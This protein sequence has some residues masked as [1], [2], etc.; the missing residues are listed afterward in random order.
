[1]DRAHRI[2]QT[3]AVC[4]YRLL[5]VKN[6]EMHIFQSASLN[7]G[8]Y[9]AVLAHQRQ[10]IK[11]DGSIDGTYK[12]KYKS[13]SKREIQAKDIDELLKKGSYD[14]FQDYNDTEAQQFMETDIYHM[15]EPIS[16]T[17]TYGSSGQ[18]TM[19]SGI[20]IFSKAICFA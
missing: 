4:V 14:V 2:G 20:G 18:S 3:R 12:K 9:R 17:V 6:Y 8:L 10:N 7:I 11:D 5:T 1:M 16:Q 15:I 19:R 13:R